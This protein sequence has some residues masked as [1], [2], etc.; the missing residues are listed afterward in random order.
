MNES[1]R[2]RRRESLQE[3]DETIRILKEVMS[4]SAAEKTAEPHKMLDEARIKATHREVQDDEVQEKPSD[5]AHTH[6]KF[7]KWQDLL[8]S[9]GFDNFIPCLTETMNVQNIEDLMV[10]T[11][12]AIEDPQRAALL[13]TAG[14]KKMQVKQ[15]AKAIARD[16]LLPSVRTKSIETD[17]S[18]MTTE[19][20]QPFP[21]GT[22][23]IS[24]H[25]ANCTNPR[26][27]LGYE[28]SLKTSHQPPVPPE[29]TAFLT[30]EELF[31]PAPPI[32]TVILSLLHPFG[33]QLHDN[34]IHEVHRM[35]QA[36]AAGIQ[37]D[38]SA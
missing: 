33:W 31:V 10:L 21:T 19:P 25:V 1:E 16:Q 13:T 23:P 30:R 2:A 18:E 12:S 14:F 37:V 11:K 3:A 36:R 28:N 29:T 15:L 7:E 4:C 32:V 8:A 38:R 17:R 22:Q 20:H 6:P 24:S 26:G 34:T 27:A 35:G 5:L 9:L